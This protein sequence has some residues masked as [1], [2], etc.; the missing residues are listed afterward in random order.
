MKIY[1]H[2]SFSRYFLILF[3]TWHSI[4]SELSVVVS[5]EC[6][7][8][9][10]KCDTHEQC[11]V[12]SKNGECVK[13]RTDMLKHCTES[14]VSYDLANN[15]DPTKFE[16][17]LPCDCKENAFEMNRICSKS[18]K[19]CL[20]TEEDEQNLITSEK[21]IN[22]YCKNKLENCEAW[23]K[24]GECKSNP[25][26]MKINCAKSSDAS[27]KIKP[28]GDA[29]TTMP[30][31][32]ATYL[33]Q[34][35]TKQSISGDRPNDVAKLR[36]EQ[37]KT[38]NYMEDPKTTRCS[39]L[40]GSTNEHLTWFEE[41]T[42]FREVSPTQ[43]RRRISVERG[44]LKSLVNGKVYAY[45]EL[46]TPSL[47]Q[48]RSRVKNA[49]IQAG[50]LSV[51]EIVGDIKQIHMDKS[52]AGAFFQV[53]SQFNLLEMISPTVTPESGVG[54]YQYD[55]TQGPA[56][57][58]AAGAGTIYRNYFVT[59]NGQTGQSSR[60]QIDCLADV[61]AKLGN[62]DSRLWQMKNGYAL[63]SRK[64]LQAI[65]KQIQLSSEEEIDDLRKSLR[66]G[67][68]WDTQVT[69]GESTH[70]V[71]QAF[72]S[73]LPVAYAAFTSISSD[74]WVDF[75]SIIL[76]ATYESVICAAI[77]NAQRTGN[78]KVYLTLVGGGAFGNRKIWI[79]NAIKRAL[80]LYRQYELEVFVVSYREAD[81]DI[82]ALIRQYEYE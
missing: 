70:T 65:T 79:L 20:P 33:E 62:V 16:D 76:E 1:V 8:D 80:A 30:E 82:Q 19:A 10:K 58:I 31:I 24:G 18:C 56:C 71:T 49:K 7:A 21:E 63:V 55:L 29:E 11:V 53:A 50:A 75:A 77:L 51:C 43:V 52:N 34:F 40:N 14:C 36:R 47:E 38:I 74:L 13:N 73:A 3:L 15:F 60:S 25:N 27:A 12:W 41:L 4:S 2:P 26:Y 37:K 69:L 78:H 5:E 57:A 9:E 72:C 28:I 59:V 32:I 67:L 23:P 54:Q 22:D 44:I 35:G 45:G 17:Q 64:G 6:S 81:S 68:Q 39:G 48:L 46:E 42:G 66:I 61:G